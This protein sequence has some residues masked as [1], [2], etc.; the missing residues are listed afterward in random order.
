MLTLPDGRSQARTE[1]GA[2]D[3]WPLLYC[4]GFPAAS[5][6]AGFTDAAARAAGVRVIA[7]DRPGFGGSSPHACDR[8]ADWAADVPPLL[9]ALGLGRV[10]VLG[11][12]G[13]A[14]YALA[15]AAR[16][17]ASIGPVALVAGL[18][19]LAEIGS[20]AGMSPLGRLSA[21]L[22]GRRP[23]LL[24]LLFTGLAALIRAWPAG[25]FRLLA[26]ASPGKDR[27]LL[28]RPETHAIWLAA[29]RGSVAQGAG[30]AIAEMRRYVRPWGIDWGDIDQPV[31]LWH[32]S[33]DGVVPAHHSRHLAAR[34]PRASLHELPGAGHFSAPLVW[35]GTILDE[36]MGP[37]PGP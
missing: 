31:T 15:S 36:L 22:A 7:P 14:P 6:E 12:S 16:L 3:G 20:A 2:P 23:G 17:P 35:I 30:P 8:V 24:A 21:C 9:D 27:E 4:H 34:L 32:G 1:Y 10:P 25:M 29:L 11:V 26:T 37:P 5:A 19:P 18:G 13:G 33:A 28:S